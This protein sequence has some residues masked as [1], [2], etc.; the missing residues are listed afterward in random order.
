VPAEGA[1]AADINGDGKLD[2]VV[3]ADRTNQ[4]IWYENQTGGV[5]KAPPPARTSSQPLD[6]RL[7]AGRDEIRFRAR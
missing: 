2:L 6:T 7:R 1:V 3:I 4:L 5:G